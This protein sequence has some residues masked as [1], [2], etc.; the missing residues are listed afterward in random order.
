MWSLLSVKVLN[1]RIQ[2]VLVPKYRQE[3]TTK[4]QKVREEPRTEGKLKTRQSSGGKTTNSSV[5]RGVSL[6]ECSAV[7]GIVQ[8]H[9]G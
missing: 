1:V 2:L 3:T 8:K 5:H 6:Q 4:R 9:S 7:K